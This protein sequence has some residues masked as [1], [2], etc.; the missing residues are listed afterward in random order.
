MV[1]KEKKY[2]KSGELK[3][4]VLI[5]IAENAPPSINRVATA[6][7]KNNIYKNVYDIVK[8]F[9]ATGLLRDFES[10]FWLTGKGFK[11]AITLGADPEKVKQAAHEFYSGE[12]LTNIIQLCDFRRTAGVEM[13]RAVMAFLDNGT[14]D[15][16]NGVDKIVAAAPGLR[17][18]FTLHPELKQTVKAKIESLFTELW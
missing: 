11:E 14:I 15:F 13:W 5:Y 17:E 7:S 8:K 4:R 9:K 3:A 2:H 12:E 18:F 6:M 1:E 10:R 16:G